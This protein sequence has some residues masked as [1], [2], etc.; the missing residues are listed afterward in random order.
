MNGTIIMKRP[1]CKQAGQKASSP[2]L[3][4]VSG[5]L[6]LNPAFDKAVYSYTSTVSKSAGSIAIRTYAEDSNATVTVNNQVVSYGQKYNS[7]LNIGDN[8]FVIKVVSAVGDD[9]RA[10]T[11]IVTRQA[12]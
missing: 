6:N 7:T 2:Y 12:V 11:F 1:I 10:Y 4:S 8:T 5:F 3:A 9:N